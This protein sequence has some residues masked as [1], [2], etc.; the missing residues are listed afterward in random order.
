MATKNDAPD[1]WLDLGNAWVWQED[2]RVRLTPKAFAVLRYLGEHA[3]RIVTKD[4]LL[5]AVWTD[6]VVSE[7]AVTT[8]LREIRRALGE[9]AKQPRYIETIQRRGYRFIGAMQSTRPSRQRST[10]SLH[11]Q[12]PAISAQVVGRETEIGKLH[13]C[14]EK[15]ARGERQIVF[16]SGEAGIGKTTLVEAF[17]AQLTETDQLTDQIWLGRGQCIDHYGAGEAYLPILEAL[18][19]L[20]RA[21][22]HES[23]VALLAQQAPTWLAQMP[24]VLH[25]EQLEALQHRVAGATRERMLREMAEVLEVLTADTL[26]VLVLED[27]HWSDPSTLDLLAYLGRRQVTAQLLII[28]TYRPEEVSVRNHPLKTMQH[29]LALH[30]LCSPISLDYLPEPAVDTYLT[31]RFPQHLFPA[32]LVRVIHQRAGGNPLFLVNL[33]NS[34]VR[35]GVLVQ[36]N[37]HWS[38]EGGIDNVAAHM[39]EN[40]RQMITQQIERLKPEQQCIL[41][42]ASVVGAE[43]SA[44]SVA[45]GV[46]AD[47]NTIEE[48][49]ERLA[50]QGLFVQARGMGEWP[51]GTVTEHYRFMH[52]LYQEVLY[53][54]VTASRRIRLHHRI[55]IREEKGYGERAGERAAELAVHFER[56]RDY[57]RAIQYLHQA[58][59]A[60]ARRSAHQ[61][62]VA[63]LTKGLGLLKFLPDTP[64]RIQ[65]EL[66]LQATFGPVLMAAKGYSA[67][68][69]EQAYTRAR[70]LCQQ[71]GNVSQLFPVLYGLWQCYVSQAELQ[72]AR[73]L[74]EQSFSLAQYAQDPDLALEAHFMLAFTL[75]HLGELV[76]ARPHFEQGIALYDRQHHRSHASQYGQEPGV[77]C[78]VAATWTLWHLGYPDQAVQRSRAALA[79]AQESSHSYS[80]AVSLT[81]AAFVHQFRGERPSAQE[82]AEAEIRLCTEQGF[83]VFLASGCILKG[84]A[85]IEQGRMQEGI[86]QMRQG[87]AAWRTTGAGVIGPYFLALLAEGYG[88]AGQARE[89]LGVLNEAMALVEKTGEQYYEAEL[90][91]LRGELLLAQE[92]QKSKGKGQK[93]KVEGVEESFQHAIAIA[94]NRQAKSLELRATTSLARLWQQGKRAKAYSLLSDVYNWFTEGFDTKDLRDAQTLL[95]ELS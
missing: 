2:K 28:G 93:S 64:E 15:A 37:G 50:R 5:Q 21:P 1:L 63:H 40:L 52:A 13:S 41:E 18:S 11:G 53:E 31:A 17:L 66:L 25:G 77:S 22:G 87:L 58:G 19:Q 16:I 95:R 85:L 79:L 8:C 20:G 42:S 83:P 69:T 46:E 29:E 7:W 33:L 74:A 45:S 84:W 9:R 76:L 61:E 34:L 65:H 70:E 78:L 38:L 80:R 57:P 82:C 59:E 91:R 32:G 44:V 75:Y 72:L 51:D 62:A 4:E 60:S 90:Y 89:G 88:K 92:S 68:E 67:P 35:Q 73:E 36:S 81:C 55:G 71:V 47:P 86:G 26:L 10:V 39:P 24:A 3:G 56:G 54:R 94:R 49:C 14:L 30:D 48:E 27:L 12:P 23:L 6:T 43:F